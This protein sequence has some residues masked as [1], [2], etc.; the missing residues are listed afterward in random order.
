MRMKL[1]L[2][3]GFSILLAAPAQAGLIFKQTQSSEDANGHHIRTVTEMRIE[4]EKARADILEMSDN[5]FMKPGGYMLF[6][7]EDTSYIV[8]PKDRTYSRMDLGEM[9]NMQEKGAQAEEQMRRRGG[10]IS[11]EDLKIK[12]TLEEPGPPHDRAALDSHGLALKTIRSTE[13]KMTPSMPSPGMM[14]GGRHGG[15]KTTTE[16]TELREESLKPDLFELPKGYT[17]TE[18]TNPNAGG[19]PDLNTIP[20]GRGPSGGPGGPQMPDLDKLPK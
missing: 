17:E 4:G 7:N 15:S 6:I 16:I 10:S 18:M 9:Q 1:P 12:K 5:P 19:V 20:G 11:V 3:V 14:F 8:N 13:S 2:I